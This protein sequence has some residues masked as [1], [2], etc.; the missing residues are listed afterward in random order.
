MMAVRMPRLASVMAAA[1]PAGPP[2]NIITSK[3]LDEGIIIILL[4]EDADK[5]ILPHH[6]NVDLIGFYLRDFVHSQHIGLLAG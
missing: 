1:A 4:N 2:P 5:V 3:D 6:V